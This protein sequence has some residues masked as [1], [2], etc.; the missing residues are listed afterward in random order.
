MHNWNYNPNEGANPINT[1]TQIDEEIPY[2]DVN[3][4]GVV[5]VA[6]IVML[7]ESII[8]DRELNVSQ[9][10]RIQNYNL[11]TFTKTDYPEPI[12]VSKIVG[13]VDYILN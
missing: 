11:P 7:V 2:A 13:I 12:N 5:D 1:Y 10:E 4:D 9:K 8:G 6:D 3:G